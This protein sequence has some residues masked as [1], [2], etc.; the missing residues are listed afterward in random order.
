MVS[1]TRTCVGLSPRLPRLPEFFA[2]GAAG[3][4]TDGA[5]DDEAL[6][7]TQLLRSAAESPAAGAALLPRVY[8]ELRDLAGAHM[9]RESAGHTLQPTALVHE[10]WMKL[11]GPDGEG[12]AWSSR[13]HFFGAAARAMRQILVDRA[14]RV[15]A[16]RH[17]GHLR[18]EPLESVDAPI[19]TDEV[20]FVGLDR[21]L[22]RLAVHDPRAA[23]IVELRFFAGLSVDDTAR[24]LG[25]SERTVAREW[26]VARAWLADAMRE[27]GGA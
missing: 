8:R 16:E 23:Q 12:F 18:R 11:V 25:I 14:R 20:D 13:A 1:L 26:N 22:S 6:P 15:R 17:G 5:M 9:A 7:L 4:H 10:A 21:A 19:P 27:E 24:A 2:Q 3:C